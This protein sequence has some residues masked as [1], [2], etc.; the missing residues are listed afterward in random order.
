M[1]VMLFLHLFS[2]VA[3]NLFLEEAEVFSLSEREK[4]KDAD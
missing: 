1:L 4:K 2:W 3:G